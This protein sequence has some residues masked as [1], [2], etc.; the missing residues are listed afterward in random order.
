[1]SPGDATVR[2]IITLCTL[3]AASFASA[4]PARAQDDQVDDDY[5]VFQSVLPNA[6]PVAASQLPAKCMAFGTGWFHRWSPADVARADVSCRLTETKE[7][8]RVGVRWR[9]ARYRRRWVMPPLDRRNPGY[10]PARDEEVLVLFSQATEGGRLRPEWTASYGPDFIAE[11]DLL[12]APATG[13]GVLLSVLECVN[14]TGGCRQ[15]FIL[16]RA[17]RWRPVRE[18]WFRHL[19]ASMQGRFWKGTYVDPVTLR[20]RGSLYA[21]RDANCCPSR[22]VTFSLALHGDSLVLRD[23]R[24]RPD[25]Q[26]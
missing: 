13:G 14:G 26:Q 15:H 12:T 24:V 7:L 17:R 20:G 11:V 25:R 1:V 8:R 2:P 6:A 22:Q 5:D 9:F 16:R 10:R 23:Y 21:D 3:L 4:L 19:P 18:P